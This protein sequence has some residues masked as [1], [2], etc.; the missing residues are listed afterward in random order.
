MRK[1]ITSQEIL[2]LSNLKEEVF[3]SGVW[4]FPSG[5]VNPL[6]NLK[7]LVSG[8]QYKIYLNIKVDDVNL[9]LRFETEIGVSNSYIDFLG[10]GKYIDFLLSP[11]SVAGLN[12]CRMYCTYAT[13]TTISAVISGTGT[14][15]KNFYWRYLITRH[16]LTI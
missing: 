12:N 5:T 2:Q 6:K 16:K 3:D 14:S 15:T 13:P 7:S 8:Y 4:D 1:M 11:A 10:V 9:V